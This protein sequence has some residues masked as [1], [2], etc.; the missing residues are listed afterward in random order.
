MRKTII[1]IIALGALVACE[2][3]AEV[4]SEPVNARLSGSF[5]QERLANGTSRVTVRAF[6]PAPEG[7][8]RGEEILGAVCDL[9]SDEL[10]ARVVTPQEVI[11]PD[12]K[13]RE[14]YPERGLPSALVI[15][16]TAGGRSGKTQITAVPKQA[17]VATGAGAAVAMLTI[18]ASAA[19]ATSTPWF[20][21]PNGNVVLDN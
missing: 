18:V 2:P 4:T 11:V 21:Q 10:S 3:L 15:S 19:I 14:A 6:M 17:S 9:R 12:F 1:S 7:K 13:Q 16:C 5:D 20:Y 8:I